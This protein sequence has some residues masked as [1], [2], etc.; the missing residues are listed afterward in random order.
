MFD[1]IEQ[2]T[3]EANERV[4]PFQREMKV[5]DH[6][7]RATQG[8]VVYGEVISP[9]SF[10]DECRAKGTFNEELAQEEQWEKN[11]RAEPHMKYYLF[12]RGY[13]NPMCM[14]GELGDTHASDMQV[15][16]TKE[17]FEEAKRLGWPRDPQ[18]ITG[19]LLRFG[20]CTPTVTELIG[21]G[22]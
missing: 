9:F 20:P 22:G 15:K 10:Y 5:G 6:F 16:I 1:G 8:F 3:K 4:L 21:G 19:L 18:V 13:S 7:L 2:G 17:A 12:T 11:M 14:E